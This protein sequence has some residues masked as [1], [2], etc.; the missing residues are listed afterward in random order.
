MVKPSDLVI[1]ELVQ[2]KELVSLEHEDFQHV[3]FEPVNNHLTLS[4]IKV[5]DVLVHHYHN[6]P[7]WDNIITVSIDANDMFGKAL[8]DV[9]L[10]GLSNIKG[11]VHS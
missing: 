6:L 1:D 2:T 5:I 11:Y 8:I 10:L 7:V 3:G 9:Y 4:S